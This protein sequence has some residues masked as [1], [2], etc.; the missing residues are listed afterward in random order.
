MLA[1]MDAELAPI[2]EAELSPANLLAWRAWTD[3][4]LSR[5]GGF[6]PGAIPYSEMLARAQLL[7]RPL[8]PGIVERIRAIDGEFLEQHAETAKAERV[9]KSP[10]REGAPPKPRPQRRR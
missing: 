4:H 8:A 1:S 3:L 7:G 2:E 6:G 9:G 10:R 5:P